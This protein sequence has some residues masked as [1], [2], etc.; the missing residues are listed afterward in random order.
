MNEVREC[1]AH[2]EACK[3]DFRLGVSVPCPVS[4]FVAGLKAARCPECGT[5][6]G[7]RVHELGRAP[8]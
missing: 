8:A 5:R 7:L 4:V 1:W 2:C 3:V 6:K